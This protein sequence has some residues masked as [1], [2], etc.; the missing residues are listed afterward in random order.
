MNDYSCECY[1]GYTGKNCEIDIDECESSPCQY[2]GRCLQKSNITIYNLPDIEKVSIPEIFKQKFSYDNA[3]GY[4]CI[5]VPGIIGRNCEININEC[6]SNPCM[7]N[8]GNCVDGVGTYTCE[9]EPGFEGTH[10][11][12][13]IDECQLY[14]PCINGTC[15]DGRDNY[16]CDCDYLFGG[17]N[18]SVNLIGCLD[19]PCL[20]SGTCIPYLENETQHKFNCSCRNGYQGGTCEKVTTM[21]LVE[22]SLLTVNTTR[23]EGYEIHLRFKTTIPN[24]R[25]AFGNGITYGYILELVNGRLNLHSSLL[26][27]WEGVFI[28]SGLND[29]KWQNVFVAINSSHLVLSANEEQTIYPINSYEGTNASHT[30]FPVTYLGGTIPNL[31]SYLRHLTHKPSSFVGCMEDVII[32]GQWVSFFCCLFD[33]QLLTPL[34]LTFIRRRF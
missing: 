26:N 13:D 18:C 31:R 7:K 29:S 19:S 4:E 3:S 6:D 23:D 8:N 1:P 15:I 9:C 16:L 28:G 2:S 22:R 11:E 5:C 30:S 14:K 20:N 10:C 27:K 33:L 17:K 25:L 34:T 12:T 21:S 32:N 24:G